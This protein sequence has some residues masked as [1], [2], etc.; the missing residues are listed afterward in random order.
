MISKPRR[1]AR[2]FDGARRNRCNRGAFLAL[3]IGLLTGVL[4]GCVTLPRGEAVPASLTVQAATPGAPKSRYWPNQDLT[5]MLRD[6]A[7]SDDR[8]RA[9]L[10]RNTR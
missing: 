9:A 1:F 3:R 10:R 8:E 7:A 5:A 6:A 2:E 4:A